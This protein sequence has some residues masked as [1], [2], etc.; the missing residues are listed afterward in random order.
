MNE[1]EMELRSWA[2]RRPS[3]KLKRRI[4]ARRPAEPAAAFSWSWLAPATAA[5]LM[6]G[7]LLNQRHNATLFEPGKT[8]PLVAMIMSNQS[9]AAS[10]PA[11]FESQQN[12]LPADTF[13][14][15]NG[16]SAPSRRERRNA[17]KPD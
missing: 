14:W 15:T 1:L 12:A 13:K 9:A 6:M 2:L 11:G 4:F 7:M 17:T 5:L 16:D 8:G 3:A 10:L